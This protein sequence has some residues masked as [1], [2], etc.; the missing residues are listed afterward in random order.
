MKRFVLVFIVIAAILCMAFSPTVTP[1]VTAAWTTI[2][3]ETNI[4]KNA[5]MQFKVHNTGS[6]PFTDCQVQSW[7][8][9]DAGDW[10]VVSIGWT[11]CQ[12]LAAGAMTTWEINGS[13]HERLRVQAKSAAGT[14]S[15]C[16]PYGN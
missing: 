1:S 8:G 7:V 9:P 12:S 16:R 14:S 3:S 5:R 13:S 15:Y 4:G 6:N 11:T 2:C 10:M